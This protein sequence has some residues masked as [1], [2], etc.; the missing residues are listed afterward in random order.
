MRRGTLHPALVPGVFEGE[1]LSSYWRRLCAMNVGQSTRSTTSQLFSAPWRS[2]DHLLPGYIDRF[3]KQ[4]GKLVDMPDASQ[5][6][7][8]HTQF[9]L[10]AA[11]LPPK[12]QN[13]LRCR[14]LYTKTG[15]V[16]PCIG[17]TAEETLRATVTVCPQCD[18]LA[19]ETHGISY[20][21]RM[22]NA[23]GVSYCLVHERDLVRVL[24]ECDCAPALQV[25]RKRASAREVDNALRLARSSALLS[26]LRGES[27]SSFRQ[28]LRSRA[29]AYG[30]QAKLSRAVLAE[31]VCD[32]YAGGF[33][34]PELDALVTSTRQA[35]SWLGAFFR[36]RP[37]VHP[38]YVALL[39]GALERASLDEAARQAG[40]GVRVA[41]STPDLALCLEVLRKERTLTQ[42]S[43]NLGIS[44]TTLATLA[45]RHNIAFDA[46]PSVLGMQLRNQ[47]CTWL[48]AG[49]AIAVIAQQAH[50][51]PV[52]IYRVLAGDPWAK[53]MRQEALLCRSRESY[54]ALWQNVQERSATASRTQLRRL[55]PAAWS[56]LYRHDRQWLDAEIAKRPCKQ[57][58]EQASSPRRARLPWTR[59]DRQL[60]QSL[61]STRTRLLRSPGAARLTRQRLLAAAGVGIDQQQ[62]RMSQIDGIVA[63]LV[64]SPRQFVERRLEQA[65][66]NARKTG[67]PPEGWLLIRMA[68]LR[69]STVRRAGVDANQW[70]QRHGCN[71]Q[72][73]PA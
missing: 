10:F 64:E 63:Q 8:A 12:R 1:L 71:A 55:S 59:I 18:R 48:A 46:K 15:P 67:L 5:W 41:R 65:L 52:S 68:R 30:G 3:A 60:T 33:E 9:A 14:M 58:A 36:A 57:T 42:A 37:R 35:Q 62:G 43:R 44:V 49:E 11:G 40:R 23:P 16:A 31:L 4:V 61:Q 38:V 7:Q 53:R 26:L 25:K 73:S 20:W 54:R 29:G 69:P 39:H 51:S 70:V 32:E 2:P 56:W 45:R 28:Q 13:E 19:I 66:H 34:S 50:T 47:V 17:L 6:L 22:H 72:R 21:H 24:P 27:L